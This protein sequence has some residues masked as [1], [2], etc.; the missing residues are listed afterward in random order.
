MTQRNRAPLRIP[1]ALRDCLTAAM[2]ALLMAALGPGAPVLAGPAAGPDIVV[3]MLDDLGAIDER[4]LERLPAIRALWLDQ[5]LRFDRLYGETPLCCPGRAEFLAGQHMASTGVDINDGRLFDP[6]YTIATALQVAGYQTM[7]VGKY[8]NGTSVIPD[9]TPPGWNLAAI[10]S[11]GYQFNKCLC[12]FVNGVRT[13]KG[14]Y[15][16]YG[17]KNRATSWITSSPMTRPLFA[18]IAPFAPHIAAPGYGDPPIGDVPVVPARL[19]GDARCADIQPWQPPSSNSSKDL[20]PTCESLL[21]VDELV[22]SIE[23][24][25][26]ARN[27]PVV[28]VLTDDNG[29]AWGQHGL[30]AKTNPWSTRLPVYI[31][32]PGVPHGSTNALL[33]SIDLAPALAHLAPADMPHADGR[34]FDI[35]HPDGDDGVLE[36]SPRDSA[37][38]V[39]REWVAIRTRQWRLLVWHDGTRQLFNERGDPWEVNDVEG[40][41]PNV[42]AELQALMDAKLA[43]HQ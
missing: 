39:E 10:Y 37:G 40:C 14:G 29:M 28:W 6:T 9:K 34:V 17:I 23:E 2:A 30:D 42:E 12:W 43:D 36:V 35:A 27:R 15:T 19:Q 20:V 7:M 4:I 8:F 16:T 26:A 25:E 38:R 32:G 41:C 5:G 3:L 1:R 21:A 33:S 22:A 18:Y 24:A 11:G 13:P 31:T